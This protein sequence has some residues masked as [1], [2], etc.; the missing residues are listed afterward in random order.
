MPITIRHTL[1]ALVAGALFI[2]TSAHAQQS[3]TIAGRVQSDVGTPLQGAAVALRGMG[4]GAMS[5][6]D[7]RY[8]FTV[9]SAR[10]TGQSAILEA[11]RLGFRPETVTV[12]LTAGTNI[13]RDFTLT[14][15]PLQL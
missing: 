3:V 9:P 12:T 10:A 14:A 11:R 2:P 1:A 8:E 4:L 6:E 15:N 7:G 13:N 5:R